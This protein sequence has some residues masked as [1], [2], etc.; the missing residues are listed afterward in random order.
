MKR[1]L[2]FLLTLAVLVLPLGCS[3]H[4]GGNCSKCGSDCSCEGGCAC[5]GS[6][7]GKASCEWHLYFR[8]DSSDG[9][10]LFAK[11]E[12]ELLANKTASSLKE[13]GFET[14]LTRKEHR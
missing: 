12:S 4:H 13:K 7:D 2:F 10:K 5:S 11:F 8:K 9:W 3:S 1:L 6:G 14:R